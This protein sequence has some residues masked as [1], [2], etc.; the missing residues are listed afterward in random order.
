MK[1]ATQ[2]MMDSVS[3]N[4]GFVWQYLPDLSR[5][6]GEMEAKRTMAWVQAPG[7]PA[8][9]HVLLDAYHA[10]GDEYYYGAAEKVA[11]ALIWGQHP[12]GG[13]NYCFDFAGEASLKDW[14]ATVG[15]NGWRLEEFQHYY[16]N[17]TFDDEGTAEA[18]KFLLRIYVEKYDPKFKPALEKAIAFVLESQYPVGGWPQRYPLMYEFSHHG[19]P[20]YTSFITLNDDVATQNIDFMIKCYQSLGDQRMMDP[21]NRAMHCILLLQQGPPQPGFADQYTLDLKPSGARTYEPTG[22]S[23][24]AT[25]G[26]IQKLMDYYR[27][28]GDTK[29]LVGI[30]AAIDWIASLALPQSEIDRSD[31]QLKPGHIMVPLFVEI[32]T[33]KPLYVHRTGSNIV[34]GYYYVDQDISKTIGHYSSQNVINIDWLRK[35]YETVQSISPE[36]ITKNSPL[37]EK[38]LVPLPRYFTPG[39]AADSATAS[40]LVAGL[41]ARG[42]WP[43]PLPI[44]SNPYIGPGKETATA[45][46]YRTTMVGDQYD[47]SPYRPVEP[48]TGIST[49]TYIQNM[50]KLNKYLNPQGK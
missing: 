20:D 5:S 9:G 50:N 27:L 40:E 25:V 30:P 22:L 32:G 15:A 48:L 2:F 12:S 43:S 8:V 35:Q 49:Q 31:K 10:T 44:T 47:T 11:N 4:G 17:A 26:C 39:N 42:Y 19:K 1:R 33:G 3:C 28:T 18:S 7:T 29:F 14:Y 37:R 38:G 16:G 41:N 21:I 46:D 13:W 6:W 36:Q 23:T 34:S 45:G 24:S